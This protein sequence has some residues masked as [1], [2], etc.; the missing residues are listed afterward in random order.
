[1]RTYTDRDLRMLSARSSVG[2]HREPLNLA[3][4]DLEMATL[5]NIDL[6]G[7]NLTKANLRGAMLWGAI[8][9][10]ACLDGADLTCADLTWSS[11]RGCRLKGTLLVESDLDEA[12]VDDFLSDAVTAGADMITVNPDLEELRQLA[13]SLR[14]KPE[15]IAHMNRAQLAREAVDAAALIA[16]KQSAPPS[17]RKRGAAGFEFYRDDPGFTADW[18]ASMRRKFDLALT[19]VLSDADLH[20]LL[21]SI[22]SPGKPPPDW[23]AYKRMKLDMALTRVLSDADMQDLLRW[24]TSTGKPLNL[25]GCNLSGANMR[26]ASLRGAS[27]ARTD[28]TGADIH[29]VDLTGADLEG[30]EG[31]ERPWSKLRRALLS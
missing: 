17:L 30:A 3:G 20:D 16:H 10:G 18:F 23:Y 26:N 1:M 2:S 24:S 5:P 7:A 28:A 6:S 14:D 21:R 8:L 19:R 27:L 9:D 31:W 12:L 22:A 25:R 29:G 15:E 11:L 13:E 4:A